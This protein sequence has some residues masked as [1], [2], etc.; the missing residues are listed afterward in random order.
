MRT[1]EEI[2]QSV[3][4]ANFLPEAKG[5]VKRVQE[6]SPK[7]ILEIGVAYGGSLRM[8]ESILPEDGLL[9]GVD[10]SPETIPR[11]TGEVSVPQLQADSKG[12]RCDWE[13]ED[14][15][16]QIYKL[17][18]P[19]EVYVVVGDSSSP[20]VGAKVRSVLQY[21][22]IELFFHDGQHYGPTPVWDF[23]MYQRMIRTGGLVCIADLYWMDNPNCGCQA[24]YR[25]LPEETK[26]GMTEPF[27]QG[28]GLWT[29]PAG[30]S[31]DPEK[32]IREEGLVA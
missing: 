17:K 24:L 18:S 30:F 31:F 7:V 13:V 25:A 8:W 9:V 28:M 12:W 1:L 22:Y 21:R 27:H 14:R 2:W 23:A 15:G 19:K 6:F 20:K 16:G 4:V 5:L 11:I 26:L 32:V 3:P 29:K 10:I